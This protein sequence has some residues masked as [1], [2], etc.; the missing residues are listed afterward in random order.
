MEVITHHSIDR[1]S[2]EAV[3]LWALASAQYP[4]QNQ[5]IL[6]LTAASI[7]ETVSVFAL[8]ARRSLEIL[9][10]G[11][12]F[13]LIQPRWQWEPISN[14]EKVHDLW[15]ALNRIIHA[16]ELKVGFEKLPPNMAVMDGG[17]LIVPYIQA[18]TDRK[19]LAFI[20]VF[21]LSHA[22]LYNALPCLVE[23]ENKVEALH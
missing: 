15:D 6:D 3:K 12:K 7:I 18:R 14:S 5:L 13:A 22:F 20:D 9:P 16:Q 21:S 10:K 23:A 11:K 2:H 19:T 8:N 1:A 4:Q 17:A